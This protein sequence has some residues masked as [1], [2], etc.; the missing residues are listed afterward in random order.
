MNRT[1]MEEVKIQIHNAH[2]FFVYLKYLLKGCL[3]Q[4]PSTGKCIHSYNSFTFDEGVSKCIELGME[5][6]EPQSPEEAWE[7]DAARNY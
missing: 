3:L 2:L 7:A 4:L 6:F 5:I 1:R